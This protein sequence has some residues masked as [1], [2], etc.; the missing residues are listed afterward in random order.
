VSKNKDEIDLLKKQQALGASKK[1][2]TKQ[3]N[4]EKKY[5]IFNGYGNAILITALGSISLYGAYKI[6]NF[7]KLRKIRKKIIKKHK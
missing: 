3:I 2:E 7:Y 4:T 5:E 6:Y 1:L